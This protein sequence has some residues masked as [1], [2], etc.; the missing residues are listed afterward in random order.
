VGDERVPEDG[1]RA[2]RPRARRARALAAEAP[3]KRPYFTNG[4]AKTLREV[5][6]RARFGGAPG[7]FHDGAPAGLEALSDVEKDALEAF[8]DLL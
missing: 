4:S 6:D 7:F 8:L 5:L 2:L 1:D 3:K